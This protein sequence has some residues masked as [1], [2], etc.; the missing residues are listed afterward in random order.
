MISAASRARRSVAKNLRLFWGVIL[1]LSLSFCLMGQMALSFCSFYNSHRALS[2][3]EVSIFVSPDVGQKDL[4]VLKGKIVSLMEGSSLREVK[5][6]DILEKDILKLVGGTHRMPVILSMHIPSDFK[7]PAIEKTVRAIE[8]MNGVSAVT[9][10]LDW[11]KKRI[12]LREAIALGIIALGAPALCLVGLLVYQCSVRLNKLF[13]SEQKLL[14]MLG[15]PLFKVALPQLLTSLVTSLTACVFGGLLLGLTTWASVPLLEE[16]FETTLLPGLGATVITVLS[17]ACAIV[18]LS[19][20][21]ALVVTE[22]NPP[23]EF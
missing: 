7:Y 23:M 3:D 15:A 17:V 19:V 20:A 14:L 11:I 2:G 22:Q 5:P 13:E 10:N 12:S 4:D 1:L 8:K 18:G 6:S 16:A 9:A 21:S